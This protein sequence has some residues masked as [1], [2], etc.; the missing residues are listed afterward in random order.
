ME[1][2]FY[3][4]LRDVVG[5][6]RVQFDLPEG[7]TVAALLHAAGDRYPGLKSLIWTPDGRFSDYVKVFVDGREARH[8]QGLETPLA[9]DASVDVF[10]PAA[11]G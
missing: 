6:K 7:A 1:V 8:L 3:A 10:P 4:T 11:G 2:C 9:A 5:S